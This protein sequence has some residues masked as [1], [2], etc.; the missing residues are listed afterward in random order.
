MAFWV[1]FSNICVIYLEELFDFAEVWL[2]MAD[3]GVGKKR[4]GCHDTLPC[5]RELMYTYRYPRDGSHG[6]GVYIHSLPGFIYLWNDH[7]LAQTGD[8][9]F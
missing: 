4:L 7:M 5:Q 2:W 1:C 3:E 8:V 9:S 6:G